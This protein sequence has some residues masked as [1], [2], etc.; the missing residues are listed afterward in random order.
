MHGIVAPFWGCCDDPI[1]CLR[2][3]CLPAGL[4]GS[5][6]AKTDGSSCPGM[7]LIYC[8]LM[9]FN[10][11]WLPH[12]QKRALLRKKYGLQEE[13]C[14]DCLAAAFCSPCALSQEAR[15]IKARGLLGSRLNGIWY[16]YSFEH[17]S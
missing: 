7:C 11:C 3:F 13:P 6:A 17:F 4:F 12:M 14:D 10:L 16:M 9:H 8:L 15:E 2:A 5:N 1:I